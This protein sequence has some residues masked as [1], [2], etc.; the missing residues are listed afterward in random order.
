MPGAVEAMDYEE[1]IKKSVTATSRGNPQEDAIIERA[2][3]A[4][5][6]E[7]QHAQE[8]GGIGNQAYQKAVAASVSEAK[9]ARDELTAKNEKANPMERD[10]ATD[11]DD[12]ALALA[13]TQSLEEYTLSQ[14]EPLPFGNGA[15]HRG[16]DGER[17]L[18]S[19]SD[20]GTDEDEDFLYSLEESKRLYTESQNKY[21]VIKANETIGE[22]DDDLKRAITESE[23]AH[24]TREEELARQ[25][26][27][28]EIV[29][30]YVKTQSTIEEERRQK[31]LESKTA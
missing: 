21:S 29:L 3:R 4:S 31:A 14:Q 11:E 20:L 27:E 15:H 12:E 17:D 23:I 9:R 10:T 22:D 5:V 7:L 24:K 26:I 25:A 8:N 6:R 19:D 30:E 2:L 13:L 18:S 28:E 16:Q 1:A